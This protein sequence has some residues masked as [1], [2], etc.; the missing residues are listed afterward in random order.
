MKATFAGRVK[1][2]REALGLSQS[3]LAEKAGMYP[4]MVWQYESGRHYPKYNQIVKL[5]TAL[6]VTCDYLIMGRVNRQHGFM[7]D[8]AAQRIAE[9]FADLTARQQGHLQMFVEAFRK[10]R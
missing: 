10:R 2:K 8:S 5:A 3:R 6:G 1:E 7:A 9:G 4:A